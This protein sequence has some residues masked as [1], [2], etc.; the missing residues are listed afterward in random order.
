MLLD[1]T[2]K[3][4]T[5][6]F[7]LYFITISVLCGQWLYKSASL[8]LLPDGS[9]VPLA[10][11]VRRL[12]AGVIPW[13]EKIALIIIVLLSA[14][15]LLHIVLKNEL[16]REKDYLAPYI[17]ILLSVSLPSQ[18]QLGGAHIAALFGLL[19]IANLLRV[20]QQTLVAGNLFI[21][22]FLAGV[23]SLF[24]PPALLLLPSVV[25]GVAF[26]KVFSWRDMLIA[27]FGFFT[28]FILLVASYHLADVDIMPS[29]ELYL[30]YFLPATK[31]TGAIGTFHWGYIPFSFIMLVCLLSLLPIG[32]SIPSIRVSKALMVF[33]ITLMLISLAILIFPAMRSGAT[34]T[35]SAIPASVLVAHLLAGIRSERK[36]N[37]LL[38][39]F[40]LCCLLL[41]LFF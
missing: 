28:P 25:V 19:S 9:I 4:Y 39:A 20:Y 32:R 1:F 22:T 18:L 29:V 37:L 40:M 35:L 24:F 13:G 26:L 36:A 2:R 31:L 23:A 7:V 15:L 33:R 5:R 34:L 6:T 10:A 3:T 27:L 21:S 14:F 12:A 30:A 38:I 11:E 17:L 16:L 41:Q 8:P